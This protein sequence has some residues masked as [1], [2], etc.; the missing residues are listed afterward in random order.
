MAHLHGKIISYSE[1]CNLD[2][3]R[4]VFIDVE[5][6]RHLENRVRNR[7][8]IRALFNM[9]NTTV[10]DYKACFELY[11]VVETG[12]KICVQIF[13]IP[14]F[15][16]IVTTP[17]KPHDLIITNIIENTFSAPQGNKTINDYITHTKSGEC[18]C[19]KGYMKLPCRYTRFYFKSFGS[20]KKAIT[21][22]EGGCGYDYYM[23]NNDKTHY[24]Y[25]FMRE[26]L[27]KLF[28]VGEIS[29]YRIIGD[30]YN[31]N[32]RYK[33]KINWRDFRNIDT[34]WRLE[35]SLVMSWDIETYSASG[36]VPLPKH[37][38]S[39]I[40][41]DACVF[42]WMYETAEPEGNMLL[43]VLLTTRQPEGSNGYLTVVCDGESELTLAHY[44]LINMFHPD[45]VV[46]WNDGCYDA[47]FLN[48]RTTRFGINARALNLCN[49]RQ[50]N[51]FD[52][53]GR[54]TIF[55]QKQLKI[56]ATKMEETL[57]LNA[58]GICCI[59]AMLSYRRTKPQLESY[60]LN[61]I[62]ERFKL[63]NKDPVTVAEI[64]RAY[65]DGDPSLV[66]KVGHYCVMDSALTGRLFAR[67]RMVIDA[68]QVANISHTDVIGVFHLA[69]GRR[70]QNLIM[71]YGTKKVRRTDVGIP[72]SKVNNF[73]GDPNLRL[74]ILFPSER[75]EIEK[76][77]QRCKY[78]GAYVKPPHKSIITSKLTPVEILEQMGVNNTELAVKLMMYVITYYEK[79]L[80]TD[81]DFIRFNLGNI[82]IDEF[83]S[84]TGVSTPDVD[85]TEHVVI[86]RWLCEQWHRPIAG[87][88]FSSLYPSII[89][90]YNYSPEFMVRDDTGLDGYTIIKQN[91]R[92]TNKNH[93]TVSQNVQ[94]FPNTDGEL[95][96]RAFG[97]LPR[98]LHDLFGK[99]VQ[100]RGDMNNI[101]REMEHHVENSV[102]HEDLQLDHSYYN[103]KQNAIKIFMNSFYG[104]TGN[105]NSPLYMV[106][107][108]GGI[109]TRGQQLWH[110]AYAYVCSRYC[111]VYY[112]DTD[113]IYVSPPNSKYRDN[114]IEYMINVL[115]AV[116]NSVDYRNHKCVYWHKLV[117]TTFREIADINT[118]VNEFFKTTHG[119]GETF[120]KMAYEEVLFPAVLIAPKNYVGIQHLER[121]HFPD[122]DDISG[123]HPS[124]FMRGMKYVKRGQPG[125][126]KVIDDFIFQHLFSHVVNMSIEDIISAALQLVR[127][128]T[129]SDLFK[130]S[131]AYNPERDGSTACKLMKFRA[132]IGN[133]IILEP[134]ERI[135]YVVVKLPPEY[136]ITD[137]GTNK[138]VDGFERF[139]TVGEYAN[140]NFE[141]DTEYYIGH[142][143][144]TEIRNFM[145]A[146]SYY[147]IERDFMKRNGTSPLLTTFGV[148]GDD[149]VW[150]T[151]YY[152]DALAVTEQIS[153]I[154]ELVIKE[155]MSGVVGEVDYK[156]VIESLKIER[157]RQ[158]V[159]T[160]KIIADK[161]NVDEQVLNA[162]V[163]YSDA[164]RPRDL[165]IGITKDLLKNRAKLT[166]Q[167]FGVDYI[168]NIYNSTE[169]QLVEIL[170]KLNTCVTSIEHIKK[171][172]AS[173]GVDIAEEHQHILVGLQKWRNIYS[174]HKV[175]ELA[176]K[177]KK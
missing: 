126:L 103:S 65:S 64:F 138:K 68:R 14:L 139:V 177:L 40:Y 171:I 105:S 106:E 93:L 112:G 152:D 47:P 163:K 99:R 153:K 59:D 145:L 162:I 75:N 15:L 104:Q 110:Q 172:V 137:R 97:I 51:Q 60:K 53:I 39:A 13:E 117:E 111:R 83:Y 155:K 92:D 100:V 107:L 32:I 167:R 26:K 17:D 22:L 101:S 41:M 115:D 116:K 63:P 170:I 38:D 173:G 131:M 37:T 130:M 12:E 89:R 50:V 49:A 70:V 77:E 82:T 30:N 4:S 6:S 118:G 43:G 86:S 134:G 87:L 136:F 1:F 148:C 42:H 108:A 20:R 74:P 114:D 124:V 90:N 146:S 157:K 149:V 21:E 123:H 27:V 34:E 35:P 5:K 61:V 85:T 154:E 28:Q 45:F 166:S 58:M 128:Q 150:N 79:C 147:E 143:L 160:I 10:I 141:I 11:G 54:G 71:C 2:V 125:I 113:S 96:N 66:Y 24:I 133:E 109:T 120:L 175:A 16:D 19:Y 164:L 48:S 132:N 169:K 29:N 46:G 88:D 9:E 142:Y 174:T 25:Q 76:K 31:P 122:F 78:E 127:E 80:V 98:I 84:V 44:K 119:G 121:V 140:G 144:E 165:I 102:E 91:I 95:P 156:S 94:Y 8:P 168:Q 7:E 36:G 33:F 3:N 72:E 62:L 23:A 55:T 73:M 135:N 129:S 161:Y 158:N 57:N 176:L 69:G 67:M 52:A 56:D 151:E 81:G 18:V 159:E